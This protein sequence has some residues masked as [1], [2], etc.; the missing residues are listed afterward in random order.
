MIKQTLN[1]FFNEKL[2]AEAKLIYWL[3]ALNFFIGLALML[4]NQLT[5]D[6]YGTIYFTTSW[7]LVIVP[8]VL[9]SSAVL[10][11]HD[12][13]PPRV[14]LTL[15]TFSL[16]ALSLCA[17]LILTQGIE[18]TPFATIDSYLA[19]ADQLLGFNQTALLPLVYKHHWLMKLF[20][21]G[22]D[23][24]IPELIVLP[25]LLSLL[26]QDRATKVFLI[27]LLVS[28]PIGTLLFYFFPTTAPASVMHSSYFTFQEHDT[29]IKF[30]EMHHHLNVTTDEGGLVAF[31]SFHVI[32]G[33]LLIYLAHSKKWLFYAILLW[34]IVMIG[35]TLAL[36][37]HYLIDVM[38]GITIA[39][40]AIMIG[41]YSY[42]MTRK[43]DTLDL[44]DVESG[45]EGGGESS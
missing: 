40:I 38:S 43:C 10:Y 3:L 11:F 28:Y 12:I 31:P 14:S 45:D 1:T 34:N 6:Y 15:L 26:L 18:T 8:L 23:S 30:Y 32:W 5:H 19:H 17:G 13:L 21:W 36:G 22:Y 44:D 2:T 4:T 25:L 24:I 41:E 42:L 39:A 37:W 16:Y 35:S 27:A 33:V 29:Y 9:L 20:M 7:Q